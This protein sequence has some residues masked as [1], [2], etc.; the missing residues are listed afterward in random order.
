[1][2]AID[3]LCLNVTG[4]TVLPVTLAEFTVVKNQCTANLNWKTLT[5]ANTAQ[6]DVEVSTNGAVTY[7][8]FQTVTAAGVS[9]DVRTYQASYAMQQGVTY[10]FRLRNGS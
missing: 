1:M 7:N 10:Y 8:K 5:E 9:N 6:F 2:V 4:G 3:A